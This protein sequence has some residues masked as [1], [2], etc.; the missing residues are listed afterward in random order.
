[1]SKLKA[2]QVS[3][4]PLVYPARKV[5]VE[6]TKAI[7]TYLKKQYE[8]CLHVTNPPEDSKREKIEGAQEKEELICV[9]NF[10][11]SEESISV[12]PK[13][14]KIKKKREKE[15]KEALNKMCDPRGLQPTLKVKKLS[16]TNVSKALEKKEDEKKNNE[17]LKIVHKISRNGDTISLVSSLDRVGIRNIG[18]IAD[19]GLKEGW[20][21]QLRLILSDQ[22]R[23]LQQERYAIIEG[24]RNKRRIV[25]KQIYI[26]NTY[27]VIVNIKQILIKDS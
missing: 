21:N 6:G 27:F 22:E 13:Y 23:I 3:E 17:P 18:N 2:L 20:L 5:I 25:T 7:K 19:S 14:G 15:I 11:T 10:S 8:K 26:L 9:Q 1:M 16:H 12:K 4:N 24:Y